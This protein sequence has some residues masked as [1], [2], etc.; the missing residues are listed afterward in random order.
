MKT[1]LLGDVLSEIKNGL[2]CQQNKSGVGDRISRIETISDGKINLSKVGYCTLSL[3][4]KNKYRMKKGDI[5]FSHINSPIHVGKTA[6][7]TEVSTPLYH[8]VNLLL[9]RSNVVIADLLNYYLKFFFQTGYWARTAKQSVNQAS[10]N[11]QDLKRIPICYPESIEEQRRVV[12]KL[13]EAF[14]KIDKAIELT[15]KSLQNSQE[16]FESNLN[17]VLFEDQGWNK[18]PLHELLEKTTNIN[19][20]NHPNS[21]FKY[22]DL[23]AVDRTS[24][25]INS[26]TRVN[27]FNAPSRAKKIVLKDDVIFGTTRPTLKRIAFINEE[28]DN[29]IC[30][31]GFCVLRANKNIVNS[32]L[33][34]YFL[35]TENFID[36]MEKQQRGTS[37]PAVTDN[38]VKA[39]IIHFPAKLHEQ[40]K[41]VN[42][43]DNLSEQTQNLQKLY[44][45]KLDNLQELK[46]SLLDKA[47]KGE[48]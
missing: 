16:L 26:L 23:T 40:E 19:W 15:Q 42:S 28:F 31:T 5:L 17:K 41:I 46:K 20:K 14:E 44:Q 1:V 18:C 43:I 13:D 12:K 32:K 25:K 22:I 45:Q 35:K 38:D 8:G 37:Y 47:F 34:Y 33:I 29:Q 24:S 4:Q 2:N 36:C 3:D 9:L 39:Q 10:V 48:L 21:E 27:S 11:Q 6:V 7:F 30:S